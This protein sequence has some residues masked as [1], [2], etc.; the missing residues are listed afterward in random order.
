MN[1]RRR[2]LVTCAAW[3]ALAWT[4]TLRAQANP[5]VVIGWLSTNH[6]DTGRGGVNAFNEGM[7]ALGWKLGAQY[8]LEERHADGQRERLPVLAQELAAKKPALIVAEPSTSARAAATAAP[9]TPIVLANGDPLSTGLV[10][11]L[12]RPSSFE[13]KPSSSTLPGRRTLSRLSRNWRKPKRRQWCWGRPRG[14]SRRSRRSWVSL[15]HN[16]GPLSA[17]SLRARDKAACSVMAL[18]GTRSSGARPATWTA[19]SKA[20]SPVSCRSN[21]RLSSNWCST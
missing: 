8:G 12:A 5:P 3:P 9:T 18:I 17:R 13:S 1:P 10:T 21:S 4:S 16:A 2:W 7:A 19:S 20:P 11:S 14:S 15:W 6:R